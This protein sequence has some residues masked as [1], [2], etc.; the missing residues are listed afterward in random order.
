M[1]DA[2]ATLTGRTVIGAPPLK[3]DM[4]RDIHDNPERSFG[5]ARPSTRSMLNADRERYR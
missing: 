4:A 1:Q 5:L 3:A 2:A